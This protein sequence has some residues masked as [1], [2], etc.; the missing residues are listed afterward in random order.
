MTP[1]E[2]NLIPLEFYPVLESRRRKL[3]KHEILREKSLAQ[4]QKDEKGK[5]EISEEE[6]ILPEI[7]HSK[8]SHLSSERAE[9]SVSVLMGQ[10]LEL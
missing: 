4:K 2:P 8:F 7:D 9:S 3:L 10:S 5:N 6:P 1:P